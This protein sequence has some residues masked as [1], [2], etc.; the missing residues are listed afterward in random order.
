MKKR[1]I[2]RIAAMMLGLTLALSACGGGEADSDQTEQQAQKPVSEKTDAGDMIKVG[3][4]NRTFKESVYLFMQ[5]SSEAKAKEYGNMQIDWQACDVNLATQKSVVENFISQGYDV[6]MIEP[7]DAVSM[8]RSAKEVQDA[9]IKLILFDTRMEGIVPDAFVTSDLYQMGVMQVEHFAKLYG[10]DKA[11]NV[12]MIDGS[13]G[14]LSADLM[15]SGVRDTIEEKYPNFEIVYEQQIQDFDREK[16]MKSMEDVISVHGDTINAVFCANDGMMLG[17][18]KA[19]K[20]AG[21]EANIAFYGGDNDKET[22]EMILAGTHNLYVLDRGAIQQGEL[23]ARA[24]Y[25]LATGA[26][27]TCDKEDEDGYKVIMS[28][29]VMVSSDNLEPSKI[30]FPELFE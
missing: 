7:V 24:A 5:Q 10:A 27:L 13:P 29:N 22:N 23:I 15:R 19:A 8:I 9:G 20:N 14:D 3:V 6:I 17:A 4:A 16:A 11:A 26:E 21:M 28:Q 18:Y 30:K 25:E 12:V 2:T 1:A